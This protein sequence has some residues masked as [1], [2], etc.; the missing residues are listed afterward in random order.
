MIKFTIPILGVNYPATV[1]KEQVLDY[2]MHHQSELI[3]F[4]LMAFKSLEKGCDFD[5]KHQYKQLKI[6][7]AKPLLRQLLSDTEGGGETISSI[8]QIIQKLIDE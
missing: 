4:L 8:R 7:I 5:V 6:E 3:P 2:F 1:K